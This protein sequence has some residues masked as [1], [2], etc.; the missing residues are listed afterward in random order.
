MKLKL[1]VTAFL[2]M[3][4][5]AGCASAQGPAPAE[6]PQSAEAVIIGDGS[7][8]F[9]TQT[10]EDWVT[11]GDFV[12]LV[13][14]TGSSPIAGE[15]EMGTDARVINRELT[16][17]VDT[18]IWRNPAAP[19]TQLPDSI[20]RPALG[21]TQD[22][23]NGPLTKL[24]FEGSPWFEIGGQYLVVVYSD[25]EGYGIGSTGSA[26]PYANGVLGEG[27]FLGGKPTAEY[28]GALSLLGQTLD[29][30]T[31]LLATAKPDPR[32]EGYMDLPARDRYSVVVYGTVV[33]QAT[34]LLPPPTAL[35]VPT[36]SGS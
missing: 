10:I 30:A 32:V 27:E 28:T 34:E 33:P 12:A 18:A 8:A 16:V 22:G 23:A 17:K 13:T 15:K 2:G 4:A 20:S 36:P 14:V 24:A 6:G 9:P 1:A 5:V 7:L 19:D 25:E 21:W 29:A 11:Y 3:L 35:P 26:L 31:T